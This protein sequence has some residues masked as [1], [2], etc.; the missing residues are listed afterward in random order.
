MKG[1][2]LSKEKTETAI[3]MPMDKKG[4][5]WNVR[6]KTAPMRKKRKTCIEMPRLQQVTCP[7]SRETAGEVLKHYL[8]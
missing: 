7:D 3:P 4:K 2:L 8:P 5:Y 1:F 6:N